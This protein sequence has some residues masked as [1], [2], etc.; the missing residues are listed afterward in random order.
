MSI[1]KRTILQNADA[2]RVPDIKLYNKDNAM[3]I[4]V[5]T[6]SGL[7]INS[8]SSGGAIW[9]IGSSSGITITDGAASSG[10]FNVSLTGDSGNIVLSNGN[11]TYLNKITTYATPNNGIE[12]LSYDGVGVQSYI[13]VKSGGS[14]T[15][16]WTSVGR[17]SLTNTATASG[18]ISI[19]NSGSGIIEINQTAAA[20]FLIA[21]DYNGDVGTAMQI[22][23]V[24]NAGNS[25]TI[26]LN[27]DGQI[28]M[29]ATSTSQEYEGGF[30]LSNS[31]T[32]NIYIAQ[33]GTG[34]IEISSR[35]T[36]A[37][38]AIY[39]HN[40]ITGNIIITNTAST[41]G[42]IMI[43]NGNN[44]DI[45]IANS[46]GDIRLTPKNGSPIILEKQQVRTT[47]SIINTD[48]PYSAADELYILADTSAGVITV[49]LPAAV[50]GLIYKIKNSDTTSAGNAVT[51]APAAGTIDGAANA[52]LNALEAKE[53]VCDGTNWW[54]I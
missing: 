31:T 9:N 34:G 38:N 2:I 22:R 30:N 40:D 43:S 14:D 1:L 11:G 35:T 3:I 44:G 23:T 33:N 37:A 27:S 48:S 4:D 24:G 8:Q 19:N 13:K 12:L 16:I 52:T 20:T 47:K 41:S 39:I 17:I 53:F 46:A 51:V 10:A 25:T 5:Q 28:Y 15:E 49:N 42:G 21:N 36:A 50:A 6:S 26:N 7:T 18:G 45:D 29:A 32:G 54:I